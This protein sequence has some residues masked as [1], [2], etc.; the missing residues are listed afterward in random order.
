M[1]RIYLCIIH[2]CDP[3]I[4][5]VSKMLAKLG[6]GDEVILAGVCDAREEELLSRQMS[7]RSFVGLRQREEITDF[8]CNRAVETTQ[9]LLERATSICE[10][11]GYAPKVLSRNGGFL[12]L[13][14]HLASEC[15]PSSI[16]L[17]RLEQGLFSKLW[18]GDRTEAVVKSLRYPVIVC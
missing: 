11:A 3:E 13:V 15:E 14:H 2:Q 6:E 10:G 5:A 17:P 7:D 12:E 4:R 16:Y 1:G 18:R 9:L 8:T